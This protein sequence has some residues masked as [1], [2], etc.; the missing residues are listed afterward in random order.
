MKRKIWGAVIYLG[1]FFCLLVES[2]NF[3]KTILS[4]I[5]FSIIMSIVPFIFKM[6]LGKINN[7]KG[8]KICLINSLIILLCVIFMFF[9][10]RIISSLPY[11]Y[12]VMLSVAWCVISIIYYFANVLLFVE[13]KSKKEI[14]RDVKP[15]ENCYFEAMKYYNSGDKETSIDMLREYINKSKS[16][17]PRGYLTFA[18]EVE[19][20]IYI[21]NYDL[22]K[23]IISNLSNAYYYL[24]KGDIYD[25]FR[26]EKS[27][28]LNPVNVKSLFLDIEINEYTYTD[29]ELYNKLFQIYNYIYDTN[30]ISFANN[31]HTVDGGTHESA[32][33][34]SLT[35][36]I[37]N[38][39]RKFK[40]LKDNDSNFKGEDVQEGL[41]AVISVKLTDAQFEGQTKAK[42]G[43]TYIGTLVSNAMTENLNDY[44]ENNPS[45]AKTLISK[46]MSASTAREKAQKARELERS[47]SS[48]IGRTRM[49]D[50]LDDCISKDATRTE[51]Y[52]VEGDSAGGSAS[53]GRDS[54]FQA[55]LP[56]WGKM[57][58]VE[59]ARV[60]KVYGNDK[61]TP[62]VVALGTGIGETFD[63]TKL[64]YDKII[65]MADAD[66]DG[67]HIRTLLLTF[68]FRYMPDLITTGHIYLAQPPLFEVKKGKVKK[69]A[70]NEEERDRYNEQ[71][72]GN[73]AIQRYKGLGEM[74]PE[75]LWETTMD[76][77]FRTMR[78][79]TM[80]DAERADGV[81][82]LLMGDEVEPRRQFI[83]E[84]AQFVENL[85][86]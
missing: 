21:D 66:V 77:A 31:I 76:P 72:G 43:N 35:R 44:L 55:I 78:K 73:A 10:F 6:S 80:A 22:P 2:N 16:V 75:Q 5:I 59:K 48:G 83:E 60:D 4:Y 8:K 39:A 25:S 36:V 15:L 38:Y 18:N 42:L 45:I 81:F 49:P 23:Y 52:I 3:F 27:L 24:C 62:V 28:K 30:I 1:M 17:I 70:F 79:V 54:N 53:K 7:E 34:T 26:L 47:K 41:I 11:L 65:I 61:L 33:K 32:F 56:L 20:N 69:Y 19:L 85:D 82:T 29:F 46:I 13:P 74:D 58:N 37:N 68:F 12:F 63:I 57:L 67:A 84:N 51:I 14:N 40:L 71:L 64:R 50:K 86:F 9:M